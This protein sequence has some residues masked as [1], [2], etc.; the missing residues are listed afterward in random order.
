[1]WCGA[2]V[3][4]CHA[5]PDLHIVALQHHVPVPVPG[6]RPRT[7][8]QQRCTAG[9]T[10]PSCGVST[11]SR[12][13]RVCVRVCVYVCVCVCV[14]VWQ[15]VFVCVWACVWACVWV[16]VC[17]CV[18]VRGGLHVHTGCRCTSSM[19]VRPVLTPRV[20]ACVRVCAFRCVRRAPRVC[21]V[22][23]A[24]VPRV[25]RACAPAASVPVGVP[26]CVCGGPGVHHACGRAH[27]T[28]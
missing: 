28:A 23:A 6:A 8:S 12:C 15:C 25:C 4:S 19:A 13:V 1:M 3:V 22:C 9:S 17:V 14:C 7:S 24:C 18:C 21:R 26:P 5:R 11:R 20:R 10:P 2:C 16:C 27:W